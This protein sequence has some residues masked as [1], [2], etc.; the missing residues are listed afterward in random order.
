M[1]STSPTLG[2]WGSRVQI[3]PLR[4][5]N[6]YNRRLSRTCRARLLIAKAEQSGTKLPETPRRVPE[7]SR[8]MFSGR[9]R[10]APDGNRVAIRAPA[11]AL[12]ERS[13][14]VAIDDEHVLCA[15]ALPQAAG[16]RVVESM[17]RWRKP[18]SD[19]QLDLLQT[20]YERFRLQ[21]RAA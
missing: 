6:P 10:A 18:P 8:S 5:K 7:K 20:I 19:R 21:E 1:S 15:R 14:R 3:P 13:A 4:P 16:A 11:I 9:S 12:G 17:A 2:D